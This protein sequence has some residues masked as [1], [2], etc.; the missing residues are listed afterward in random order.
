MNILVALIRTASALDLLNLTCYAVQIT[1]SALHVIPN[2]DCLD[3]HR[4]KAYSGF[5]HLLLIRYI[6]ITPTVIFTKYFLLRCV[7][8]ARS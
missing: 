4:E 7:P 5:S 3:K 8:L 1:L 2:G 6:I